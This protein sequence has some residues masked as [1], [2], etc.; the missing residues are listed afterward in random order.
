MLSVRV[1]V[2][3]QSQTETGNDPQCPP[4]GGKRDD[5]YYFPFSPL[6]FIRI[7]LPNLF[8][9]LLFFIYCFPS[10]LTSVVRLWLT[11]YL[12]VSGTFIV[13]V[14]AFDFPV[15]RRSKMLLHKLLPPV[16]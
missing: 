13:H 1:H 12:S 11:E 10:T 9:S 7:S 2:N 16:K 14:G 8:I 4:G 6:F 15:T 5:V 3:R